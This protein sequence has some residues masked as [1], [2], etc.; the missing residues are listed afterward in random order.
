MS[1]ARNLANLL[2]AGT[3]IATASIADDA[4]TS[5]KLD[6]NIAVDGSVT[7]GTELIGNVSGRILLDSSASGTDVGE[8]F[9][10]D[11]SASGTDVG[12]KIL[13]EEGT[14]DP[15]TLINVGTNFDF[16]Q[17]MG[18][19]G[20]FSN[21]TE[22]GD[23]GDV[24]LSTIVASA[25]A[26]IDFVDLFSSSFRD[27]VLMGSN[28]HTSA[29]GT[30]IGLRVFVGGAIKSDSHYRYSRIRNYSG[31]ATVRGTAE[32]GD[33]EF[34]S[35]CGYGTGN[36]AGEHS[37][38]RMTIYNPLGTD[39]FKMLESKCSVTDGNP[40]QFQILSSGHYK[41]GVAA[42]TGVRIFVGGGNI[43]TGIFKL[44]GK[45]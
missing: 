31:D 41:N 42:L 4:I 2:G 29:N 18:F 37:N 21:L 15:N 40:D 44:Y 39:N 27:Y 11:A 17:E 28:I 45:R 16:R 43:A 26:E 32:Q 35:F 25:D 6:T 3:T 5:A 14:D 1:N 8:E 38:F 24:L 20:G 12:G 19:S 23:N 9:L 22:L 33:T 7:A 13:F 36:A 30:G 34:S 10:L